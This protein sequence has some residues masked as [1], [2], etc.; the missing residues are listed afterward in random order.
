MTGSRAPSLLTLVA[1]A[2]VPLASLAQSSA[3]CDARIASHERTVEQVSRRPP[4]PGATPPLRRV[5]WATSERIELM[6]RYCPTNATYRTLIKQLQDAYDQAEVACQAMV[7][8]KS[9]CTPSSQ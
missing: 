6:Q 9:V 8:D 4:P 1:L 3:D 7:S 5:M 2:T